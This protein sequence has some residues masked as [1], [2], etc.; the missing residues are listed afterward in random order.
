LDAIFSRTRRRGGA[1][2]ET[3]GDAGLKGEWAGRPISLYGYGPTD[4]VHQVFR[5]RVMAGGEYRLS[6]Q[7]V[8]AGS[9]IVQDVAADPSAIGCASIFFASKRTRAVSLAGEDGRFYA[10]TE[11]NVRT[12]KYPL[13]RFVTICVNKPTGKAL[14]PA[15]AEFLRFLLSAE[16]QQIVAAGGNVRLD[17]PTAWQGRRAVE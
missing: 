15:P 3:W 16:G 14:A 5:E 2:I 8:P 17:A 13:T 7:V 1:A 10:P 4:G 12:L 11:E 9:L 6:L